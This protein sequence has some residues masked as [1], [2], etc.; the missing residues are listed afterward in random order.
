ML[1]PITGGGSI[2]PKSLSRAVN[3]RRFLC[4]LKCRVLAHEIIAWQPDTLLRVT[5][6]VADDSGSVSMF[7]SDVLDRLGIFWIHYHAE[8]RTHVVDPEH[9]SGF[10]VASLTN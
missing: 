6:R 8:A 3:G 2:L 9:F 10:D 4:M 5:C 1:T 7:P